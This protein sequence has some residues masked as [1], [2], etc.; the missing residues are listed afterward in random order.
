MRSFEA[1]LLICIAAGVLSGMLNFSYAFG[2]PITLIAQQLG[3]TKENS[4]NAVYLLA[5]PAGGI[6][7]IGY[8]VFLIVRRRSWWLLYEQPSAVYWAGAFLMAGLWTGLVMVYGWGAADLGRLGPSLDWSLWNAVMIMT[9]VVC[10][11]LTHEWDGVRG[12]PIHV[13]LLGIG[14]LILASVLLGIGGVGSLGYSVFPSLH[15]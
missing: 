9:T 12:R 6:L 3:A 5:L 14:A 2:K 11:L 10:G 7:N 8:C 13:L 4:P 1:G 15:D